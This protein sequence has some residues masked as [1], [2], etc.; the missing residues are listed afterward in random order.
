[1]SLTLL[2]KFLDCAQAEAVTGSTEKRH[3]ACFAPPRKILRCAT[4]GSARDCRSVTGPTPG[5]CM[6]R[7]HNSWPATNLT[8]RSCRR[9]LL[10][11]RQTRI[12]HDVHQFCSQCIADHLL[13]HRLRKSAAPGAAQANAER[14]QRVA[15]RVLKIE[16]FA[17]QIA[18]VLSECSLGESAPAS[19]PSRRNRPRNGLTPL[20]S[21]QH[22]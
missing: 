12:G 4:V 6:K 14:L 2:Y 1:M 10:S 20:G 3:D 17:L 21:P 16:E 9:R 7:R 18:P 15:D 22:R 13:A 5:I 11:Q 8:T 19:R